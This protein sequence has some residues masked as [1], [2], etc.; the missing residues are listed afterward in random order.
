M[1]KKTS[2]KVYIDSSAFIA[3]LDR[4]DTY[5]PLFCSLFS[6]PPFLITT[7]LVISETHAWFLKRYDSHRALQFL[8]F[9]EELKPLNI[10]SV[11]SK[12]LQ[13]SKVFIKKYSDQ[14]LTLVDA[15]GLWLM[16]AQKITEC[17]STD[18]HL[19]LSGVSLSIY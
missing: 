14:S 7:S 15:C 3:F 8:N 19:S 16:K 12:E 11:G 1:A 10:L 4:S 18:R 5:H 9:I 2:K 17:W 6:D 13:H